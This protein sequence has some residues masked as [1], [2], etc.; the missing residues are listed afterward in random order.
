MPGILLVIVS[1]FIPPITFDLHLHDTYYVL[2]FVMLTWIL[3]LLFILLG[4]VYEITHRLLFSILL[5][6]AH[7][8][9][10][11]LASLL[12]MISAIYLGRDPEFLLDSQPPVDQNLWLDK[13]RWLTAVTNVLL[14]SFFA[15][16]AVQLTLVI[17]IIAG[18]YRRFNKR[19]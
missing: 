9:V 13:L 5:T 6:W 14:L 11:L 12:M 16:G 2:S 19:N 17:N 7:V 4:L 1:F 3:G 10:T 8:I 18:L 15:L